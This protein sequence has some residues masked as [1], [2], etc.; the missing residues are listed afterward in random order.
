MLIYNTDRFSAVTDSFQIGRKTSCV[1][2]SIF[3]AR[4]QNKL[5]YNEPRQVRKIELDI[6][7]FSMIITIMRNCKKT[8]IFLLST[9][10]S[11]RV[12]T[13]V[14]EILEYMQ[15]WQRIKN[16]SVDHNTNNP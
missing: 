12:K 1:Y 7:F 4:Y 9:Y 8:H 3:I 14:C 6:F 16:L 13:A 10:L 2:F 15:K 11:R 5:Y